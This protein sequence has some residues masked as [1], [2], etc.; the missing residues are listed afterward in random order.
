[1]PAVRLLVVMAVTRD[2]EMDLLHNAEL[3]EAF[4]EFDKVRDRL[5][6]SRCQM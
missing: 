3:K 2:E 6:K 5:D 4:D 1:M